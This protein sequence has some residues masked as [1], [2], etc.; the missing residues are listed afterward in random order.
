MYVL[1]YHVNFI[2]NAILMN[3]IKKWNA[4][5]FFQAIGFLELIR[6]EMIIQAVWAWRP[7]R[8]L[9]VDITTSLTSSPSQPRHTRSRV[10]RRP[11]RYT[12]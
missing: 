10:V 1:S 3:S 5:S 8:L 12:L 4:L 2:W 6:A 9:S 7:G 11:D